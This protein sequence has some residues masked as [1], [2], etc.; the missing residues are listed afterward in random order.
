MLVLTGLCDFVCF[1]SHQVYDYQGTCYMS[2]DDLTS[3]GH[4]LLPVSYHN[5][6]NWM[7]AQNLPVSDSCNL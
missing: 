3:H 2:E 5:L 1:Y 6:H 7:I 4:R